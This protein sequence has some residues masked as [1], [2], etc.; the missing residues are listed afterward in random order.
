MSEDVKR[1]FSWSM[2]WENRDM[3]GTAG[4]LLRRPLII[5]FL[6]LSIGATSVTS[7]GASSVTTTAA[8]GQKVC[9]VVV[10]PSVHVVS[11]GSPCEISLRL[12]E[13]VRVKLRSGYRW[14]YP[15]SNSRAVV[16]TTISRNSIGVDAMTLHAAT[17][18][19][20]TIR[21]TGTVY[22]KPGVACPELALLWN[23]KV[24][25][26]KTGAT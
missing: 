21:V 7:A 11:K 23:L 9:G 16:V 14:G 22:C 24:I 1:R 2:E 3:K 10:T 15:V 17:L 26:T 6:T 12:G 19:R 13:H 20:A 4:A 25:V 18:G 8:S 5:A